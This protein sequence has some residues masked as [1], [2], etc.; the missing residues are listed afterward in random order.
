MFKRKTLYTELLNVEKTVYEAINK[1]ITA[2]SKGT[3]LQI[4]LINIIVCKYCADIKY[5]IC[6]KL[7]RVLVEPIS[8][9]HPWHQY[10]GYCRQVAACRLVQ[11]QCSWDLQC[12]V[13]AALTL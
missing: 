1:L 8:S 6:L 3:D 4:I 2:R 13:M 9:G 5:F 12:V 7:R 10:F 11:D